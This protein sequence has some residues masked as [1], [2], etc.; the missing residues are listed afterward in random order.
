MMLF[1]PPADT[2][3]FFPAVIQANDY[4][5][6]DNLIEI[7]KAE[8]ESVRE[9]LAEAGAIHLKGFSHSLDSFD[10]LMKTLFWDRKPFYSM[11][12]GVFSRNRKSIA[13]NVV[14][15]T[16][17]NKKL[18]MAMHNEFS[19]QSIFP[20]FIAFRC[21]KAPTT[22][23]ETAI[24]DC[25]K[26]YE[27]MDP[28]IRKRFETKKIKY[29]RNLYSK[30][31]LSEL[32]NRFI[33]IDESWMEVFGTNIKSEVEKLCEQHQLKFS[34]KKNNHLQIQNILPAV[35]NHPTTKAT[36]WF[37][38]AANTLKHPKYC[39]W[40]MY[41]AF[42]FIYP[43]SSSTPIYSTYGDGTKICHEEASHIKKIVDRNTVKV[44]WFE[45]DTL[46]MDNYLS[47]HTRLPFTGE[48]SLVCAMR[49]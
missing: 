10:S 1:S 6:S 43:T 22:G 3:L 11:Q 34:W 27:E 4:V 33:K 12:P 8:K 39:G 36:V 37:N 49:S 17:L 18:P 48:R 2:G 9:C 32:I 20:S 44:K 29:V 26:I 30:R 14:E 15:G 21:L 16:Y 45:G 42:K 47:A 25:R 38:I 35:R 19:Y 28:S 40:M 23:G 13:E 5:T 31:W 41:L 7:L 24:A 46:I